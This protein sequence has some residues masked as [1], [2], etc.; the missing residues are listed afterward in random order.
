MPMLLT[1]CLIHFCCCLVFFPTS[2]ESVRKNKFFS[3]NPQLHIHLKNVRKLYAM[4]CAASVSSADVKKPV[5]PSPVP[6][7]SDLRR[8]QRPQPQV[9]NVENFVV[10]WLDAAIGSNTDTQ[11]SK[12][13]LQQLVNAVKIFTNPDECRTF[14]ESVKEEKIFLIVSDA[15][16]EQYTT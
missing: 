4:G 2:R 3:R 5:S 1:V 11:K 9:D 8:L 12:D 15:L 13:Q 10:V 14:I 16:G 6:S 7:T